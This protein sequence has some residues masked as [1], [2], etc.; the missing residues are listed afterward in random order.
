MEYDPR[1]LEQRWRERWDREGSYESDPTD[2]GE[3]VFITVPYPYPSADVCHHER[4][5]PGGSDAS[6]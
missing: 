4:T 6:V 3:P 1:E 2:P 5:A